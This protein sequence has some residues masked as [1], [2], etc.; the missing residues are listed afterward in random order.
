MGSSFAGRLAG[1]AMPT[2]I[3]KRLYLDNVT[4]GILRSPEEDFNACTLEL[5]WL[6]NQRNISCI[7]QGTYECKYRKSPKNGDVFELEGVKNRSFIQVHAGNFK[8]Q[9]Q[10]C[11]LIGKTIGYYNADSIPDVGSSKSALDNLLDHYADTGFYLIVE[12]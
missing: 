5:P 4:I 8:Y 2:L 6:A 10:G 7:P 3:L 9:T 11:I 12:G 1:M